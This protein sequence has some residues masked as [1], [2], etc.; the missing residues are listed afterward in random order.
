LARRWAASSARI[1]SG[2]PGLARILAL[3]FEF[4]PARGGIGAVAHGL[5]TGA[6]G[7]GHDVHVLAPDYGRDHA[8]EDGKLPFTVRRFPG[9]FCSILSTDGIIRHTERVRRAITAGRP[10]VIHA[11]DPPSQMALAMLARLRLV[12]RHF[13]TIHGTELLRFR[14]EAFPRLWM[15]GA[16]RRA[17][18]ISAV[19][20]AV[21]DMLLASFP[22]DPD[23]TFV[24]WPGIA[25]WWFRTPGSDR[26]S[27]RESWGIRPDDVVLL[28]L[29]RRVREKGHLDVIEALARLAL[30][31]R[32]RVVYVIAG[33]GRAEY[34]QEIERAA[35]RGEVRTVLLGELADSDAVAAMDAADAFIMLSRE[36]SR[37]LEGLGLAFVEAGARVIPS[38]ARDTG[39]V[40][41]AVLEGETG[42]LLPAAS[43]ADDTA[44]ALE[45]LITD[46]GLRARLGAG[47]ARHAAAFTLERHAREVYERFLATR[48]A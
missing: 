43:G 37:R 35:V 23:T 17:T 24:A 38:V 25:D 32:R 44:A 33:G 34:G 14:R 22:A 28:T 26:R 46:P 5:A 31:T 15:R 45:R 9:S 19:S 2:E 27:T 7:L 29:A 40:R 16:M 8:P 42:L 48:A 12:R 21:R 1:L 3:T 6:A 39:G 13:F 11:I 47:A 20:R 41:D 4:P 10:D 36:T 18:A 30:E